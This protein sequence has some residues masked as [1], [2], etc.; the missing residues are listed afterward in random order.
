MCRVSK[1]KNTFRNTFKKKEHPMRKLSLTII[2]LLLVAAIHTPVN[3]D[4]DHKGRMTVQHFEISSVYGYREFYIPG[5]EIA[6]YVEGKSPVEIDAE[7]NSGFRVQA[8][9]TN[10]TRNKTIAEVDGNYDE[11]KRAWLVTF[12]APSDPTNTYKINV[13]F[14]CATEGAPCDELYGRAARA[15]KYLPL[16]IH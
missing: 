10:E 5:E 12:T 1:N 2:A 3:A 16:Q 14:Y 9:I 11:G 13:Y 6:F 8:S 4:Q 15:I 7:P